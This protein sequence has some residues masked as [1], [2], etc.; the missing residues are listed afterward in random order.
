MI[1]LEASKLKTVKSEADNLTVL[2]LLLVTNSQISRRAPKEEPVKTLQT[3]SEKKS[4]GKRKWAQQVIIAFSLKDKM[5]RKIK[6]GGHI[7]FIDQI[8][9]QM[10]SFT[11]V[12]T[13]ETFYIFVICFI[14]GTLLIAFI[15]SRYVTIKPVE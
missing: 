11:D 2:E 3:K 12:F 9:A 14:T 7:D 1:F 8:Y 15:L 10:P 5:N 13:E 4:A 6:G